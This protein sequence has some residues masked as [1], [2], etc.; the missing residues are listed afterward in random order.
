MPYK[1]RPI[2]FWTLR[3]KKKST[4][5]SQG[6]KTPKFLKRGVIF[7]IK[8]WNNEEKICGKIRIETN[9]TKNLKNGTHQNFA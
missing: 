9:H 7:F 2:D 8:I 6:T 1:K 4:L 5:F 3:N